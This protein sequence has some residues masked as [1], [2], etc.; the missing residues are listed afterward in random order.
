MA[1]GKEL[2][3]KMVETEKASQP[4][5]VDAADSVRNEPKF[6]DFASRKPQT[7]EEVY[8]ETRYQRLKATEERFIKWFKFIFI[9]G[10]VFATFFFKRQISKWA[11]SY[12]KDFKKPRATTNADGELIGPDGVRLIFKD[13]LALYN[14]KNPDERWVG[15]RG[16]VLNTTG[17]GD[18]FYTEGMGY[19]FF[20]GID[21]TR[22]FMT[23]DF[24]E[25]GL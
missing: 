6:S 21:A 9:F 1:D 18:Q 12:V 13:E 5:A 2:N 3:S 8:K 23:G 24:D 16:E 7:P 19:E 14:S 10:I 22:A 20:A 4:P 25:K 17:L 11:R 15:L